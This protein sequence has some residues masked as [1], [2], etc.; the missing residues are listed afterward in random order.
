ME[1]LNHYLFELTSKK[2]VL[3]LIILI[4]SLISYAITRYGIIRLVLRIFEKT[5]N[6]IDDALIKSGFLNRVSYAAPLLIIYNMMDN[7]VGEYLMVNRIL[8]SLMTVIFV[9][10]I[11]ALL[12]ATNDIYNQSQYSRSINIKSYFQVIKLFIN[13][14]SRHF[15]LDL[16]FLFC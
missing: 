16:L 5:S 3:V 7:I 14:F 9:S 1:N 11:N 10:C 13:L 8:L 15:S 6:K 4:I 2:Y 12:N